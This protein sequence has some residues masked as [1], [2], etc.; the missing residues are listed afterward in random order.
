[1]ILAKD[2]AM[3]SRTYILLVLSVL[4]LPLLQEVPHASTRCP[5][6]DKEI[7]D[8][9]SYMDAVTS[10]VK[11]TSTCSGA[12]R[13]MDACQFGTSGDNELADIVQFKCEPLFMP[14]A[15]HRL[16]V[17]YR[18][19]LNRCD[20][21]AKKNDGTMYMSFAAVCRAKTSQDFAARYKKSRH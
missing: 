2:Q 1:M 20:D 17:I 14:T 6:T 11:Q 13:I 9:S 12:Y 3:V 5:V 8:A 21:I 16:K 4:A 15:S 7:D 18:K 19:A 10:R